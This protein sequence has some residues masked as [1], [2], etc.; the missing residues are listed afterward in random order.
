MLL[1][2]VAWELGY[3]HWQAGCRLEDYHHSREHRKACTTAKEELLT[4]AGTDVPLLAETAACFTTTL[5]KELHR[6][7]QEQMS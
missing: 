3:L 6:P 2:C 7:R 1:E 5:T 4:E